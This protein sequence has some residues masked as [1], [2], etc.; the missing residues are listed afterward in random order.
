YD[1]DP[2]R[3]LALARHIG[4]TIA[5][6]LRSIGIDLNFGPVLDLD[7]GVSKVIGSRSF[8]AAPDAVIALSEAMISAMRWAGMAAVG[9][10]FP[11]H[12]GVVGDT[13]DE[14]VVD[15][16][17]LA[18]LEKAD[19]AVYATSILSSLGGVMC[20]HVIHPDIDSLPAGFSRTWLRTILRN[21]LGFQGAILSDDLTMAAA[22]TD[23]S[24]GER[25]E[26]AFDAGCD[27]VLICNDRPTVEKVLG[28]LSADNDESVLKR[29]E[30]LRGGGK[31]TAGGLSKLHESPEYRRACAVIHA[32]A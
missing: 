6:E 5:A 24:A 15:E 20:S 23:G 7:H 17:P 28:E 9:K 32:S 4:W 29:I 19:L 22:R 8:H 3:A 31:P 30:R 2:D 13:H 21:R 14:P 10:H 11:G 18:T 1:V 16:R 25:V 12:G 27:M 26:A